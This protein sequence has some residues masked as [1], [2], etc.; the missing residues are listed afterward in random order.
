MQQSWT[1]NII[2][3]RLQN[4]ISAYFNSFR[5]CFFYRTTPVTAFEVSI[6]IKKEFLK[7]NVN[8]AIA[9]ALISLLNVLIQKP[10]SRSITTIAFVFA[11]KFIIIK[12]FK[13]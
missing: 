2:K 4:I 1:Y 6:S 12:Y 9:F 5:D 13:Q 7:K 3:K 11:A 8:G 10:A